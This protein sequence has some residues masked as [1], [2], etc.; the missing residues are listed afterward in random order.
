M[1]GSLQ[2]TGSDDPERWL[3]RWRNK[4]RHPDKR[5]ARENHVRLTRHAALPTPV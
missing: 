5:V 2:K 4:K 1:A 3:G